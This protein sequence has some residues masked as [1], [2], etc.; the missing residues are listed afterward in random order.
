[1]PAERPEPPHFCLT[2]MVSLSAS[3]GCACLETKED[4]GGFTAEKMGERGGH[5]HEQ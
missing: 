5:E 4:K 1:M 3:F 2:F